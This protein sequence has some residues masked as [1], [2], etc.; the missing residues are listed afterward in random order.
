MPNSASARAA[1]VS[2]LGRCPKSA[3]AMTGARIDDTATMNAERDGV[4]IT[5]P[6]DWEMK[7]TA[8]SVPNSRPPASSERSGVGRKRVP[9]TSA[10][11]AMPNRTAM[12]A[13][14]VAS[15]SAL[16]TATK[17]VPHKNVAASSAR[18]AWRRV[19]PD[20]QIGTRGGLGRPRDRFG[21]PLRHDPAARVAGA[22]AHLDHPV[23]SFDDVEVMLDDQHGVSG[24]HQ[25][26]QHA[27]QRADVVQMQAGRGLVQDVELAPPPV[28]FAARQRQLPRDLEALRLAAR[29]R[30][31]RLAE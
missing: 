17:L 28:C 31:G 5:R 14:G 27:A 22:R 25:A 21:R 16:L 20:P 1:A 12:K 8:T 30:G 19:T 15:A 10:R 4:V 26:I 24:V 29:E 18:S 3:R 2:Q 23:G 11:A 6:A 7:P 13:N 9:G